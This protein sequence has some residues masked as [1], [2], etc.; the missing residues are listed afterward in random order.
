MLESRTVIM[1]CPPSHMKTNS[2]DC[3]RLL[4]VGLTDTNDCVIRPRQPCPLLTAPVIHKALAHCR[5]IVP[6][7]FLNTHLY[8]TAYWVSI[9]P[10]EHCVWCAH[11]PVSVW[12][13]V[14][15][16]GGFTSLERHA[17]HV[18]LFS[19]FWRCACPSSSGGDGNERGWRWG[20][21]KMNMHPPPHSLTHVPSVG[22]R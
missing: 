15:F 20:G 14:N 8:L 1:K 4:S 18:C 2:L 17:C 9:S 10:N 13:C 3:V 6:C 16:S 11:E 19:L 7:L 22:E 21:P 5:E 12:V